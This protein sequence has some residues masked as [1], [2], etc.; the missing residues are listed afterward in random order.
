M[1]RVV[2]VAAIFLTACEH[3]AVER[4]GMRA[5]YTAFASNAK[6]VTWTPDSL[7]IVE[8]DHAEPAVAVVRTVAAASLIKAGIDAIENISTTGITE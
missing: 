4:E 2:L 3:V 6:R 8:R 7:T 5:S 1:M